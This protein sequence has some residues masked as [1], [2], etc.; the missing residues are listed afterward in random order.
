MSK[1][2]LKGRGC[3]VRAQ[4]FAAVEGPTRPMMAQCTEVTTY[5]AATNSGVILGYPFLH[6]YGPAILAGVHKSASEEMR[7][8]T[9]ARGDMLDPEEYLPNKKARSRT[10]LGG[11]KIA[12]R[13]GGGWHGSPFAQPPPPSLLGRRAGTGV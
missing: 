11:K 6:G 2:K 13:V 7:W 5:L 9:E 8:A 3:V 12:L 10:L 4:A 1:E